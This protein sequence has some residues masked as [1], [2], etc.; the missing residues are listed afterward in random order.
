M[1][2]IIMRKQQLKIKKK[3]S[4]TVITTFRGL[5]FKL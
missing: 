2:D 5:L 4:K 3:K 1:D